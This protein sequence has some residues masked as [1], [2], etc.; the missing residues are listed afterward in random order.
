M[1]MSLQ[2]KILV[3]GLASVLGSANLACGKQ[4]IVYPAEAARGSILQ[5][6][7][8]RDGRQMIGNRPQIFF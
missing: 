6:R 1:L 3:T 7:R 5:N 2:A 4:A 8:M